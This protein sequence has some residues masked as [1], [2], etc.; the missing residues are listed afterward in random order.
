M[1]HQPLAI[2]E[3]HLRADHRSVFMRMLAAV[4]L[5]SGSSLQT[6]SD[7]VPDTKL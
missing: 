2:D 6:N 3:W 7:V 5:Y 1:M 4:K